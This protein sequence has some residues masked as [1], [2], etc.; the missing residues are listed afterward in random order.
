MHLAWNSPHN[1][2]IGA[3]IVIQAMIFGRTMALMLGA[4]GINRIAKTVVKML[5]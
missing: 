3:L 4:V 1:R 5:S 2:A